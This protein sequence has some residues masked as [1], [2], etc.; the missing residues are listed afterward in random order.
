MEEDV[1]KE[2]EEEE[3]AVEKEDEEEEK[4][5]RLDA[6]RSKRNPYA[7]LFPRVSEKLATKFGPF[8]FFWFLFRCAF[9]SL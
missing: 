9:A 7:I 2:E 5:F 3:K 8:F 1:E 4:Q 6:F